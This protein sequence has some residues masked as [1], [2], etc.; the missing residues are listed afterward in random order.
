MS[1][2]YHPGR[3]HV[4]V[5]A[6]STL[7]I[8][9]TSH[10]EEQK[11]VLAKDVRRIALFEVRLVDSTEWGMVVTNA[12][13]SSLVLEVK[14]KKDQD[15]ILFYL[16]ASV[17]SQRVLAFEQGGDGILKYQGK[18]C[19]PKVDGLQERILEE[20][21]NSRYYIHLGAT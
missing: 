2:I 5:D 17:H 14:E 15:S 12:A 16:K 7:S 20:A 8:W 19:V 3:A 9:I 4:V 1:I 6:F 13:E 21:H 18:L 11:W 10:V